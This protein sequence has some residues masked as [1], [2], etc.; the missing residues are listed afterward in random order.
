MR[1]RL[2]QVVAERDHYLAALKQHG[3]DPGPAPVAAPAAA[4][5]PTAGVALPGAPES[6]VLPSGPG[7]M[8]TPAAGIPVPVVHKDT[9]PMYSGSLTGSEE[10]EPSGSDGGGSH[11]DGN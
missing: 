6:S 3:I 10:P 9:E 5:E 2:L 7:A 8:G 1:A 4:S 11:G